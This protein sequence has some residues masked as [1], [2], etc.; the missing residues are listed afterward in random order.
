MT[1]SSDHDELRERAGAYALGILTAEERLEFE[2]HLT[3]CD[4][5][6]AEARSLGSVVAALAHAAPLGDL[7]VGARDRVLVRVSEERSI[8]ALPR[9]VPT[10]PAKTSSPIR[11]AA[12]Q[13]RALRGF[14]P[15]LLAAASVVLAAGLAFTTIGQRGRIRVLEQKIGRAHV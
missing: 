12:G 2:A 14:A 8:S 3:E 11:A 13:P 9:S 5:C 4:E 15:W 7:P 6:A 1:L 10:S